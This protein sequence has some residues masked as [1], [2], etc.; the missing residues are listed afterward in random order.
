VEPDLS[1][2]CCKL[3]PESGLGGDK[4]CFS[5]RQSPTRYANIKREITMLIVERGHEGN[6]IFTEYF[7]QYGGSLK[8]FMILDIRVFEGL[9]EA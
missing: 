4:Q 6:G 7:V 1:D 9:S 2:R 5:A 8:P 3:C